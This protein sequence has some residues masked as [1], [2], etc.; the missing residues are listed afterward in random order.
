MRLDPPELS[1]LR[2]YLD[3]TLATD[4]A[5]EIRKWLIVAATPE[6]LE[7]LDGLA[8]EIE[9][10]RAQLTYWAT[11]ALRARLARLAW[12]ARCVV[13]SSLELDVGHRVPLT[14]TLGAKRPARHPAGADE[15]LE[16]SPG[17]ECEVVVRIAEMTWFGAYAVEQNGSLLVM[18]SRLARHPAGDLVEAGGIV[19]DMEDDPVDVFVVFDPRGPLPTPPRGADGAWLAALLEESGGE[20]AGRSVLRVTLKVAAT[21][22]DGKQR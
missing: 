9:R 18:S 4:K 13:G 8:A 1:S 7:I 20:H 10:S 17:Q 6:V 19:M 22:S 15:T 3:G 16:V 14:G 2:Q 12:R 5:D 21:E 11:H